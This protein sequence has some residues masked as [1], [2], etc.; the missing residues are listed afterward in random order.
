[1]DPEVSAGRIHYLRW[2][3]WGCVSNPTIHLRPTKE[4][5]EK[6]LRRTLEEKRELDGEST[7][8]F[9]LEE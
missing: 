8:P 3:M 4:L 5:G 1:M 9:T 7:H 2:G 6:K